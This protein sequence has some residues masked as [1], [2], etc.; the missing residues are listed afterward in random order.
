[1]RIAQVCP[2]SLS[3]PGGVQ[4]Q[5][6]GLARALRSRGH[7]VRVI[8][9]VDH[10][11]HEAGV[12]SV[13]SSVSLPA[14]GSRAP[15]APWPWSAATSL[16]ALAGGG[17]DLVHVHEPLVPGP[18]L[19]ALLA[20]EAP[21]VG[22]FHRSGRSL[23]YTAL[24]PVASLAAR[25]LAVRCAVSE[26]A[27]AT[28]AEALPGSYE[29]LF[30]GVDVDRFSA[31]RPWPREGP[32]VV[33]VG[34]HEARKGLAVLLKAWE[35]MPAGTRCWVVGEG[36]ETG[37]LKGAFAGRRGLE[38]VGAV[39]DAE[40]ASRLAGADVACL[41]SLR[42]E[43]FGLVLLEAMAAGTPV[44]ASDLPGYRGAAGHQ[45]AALLVAPGDP[46]A[47]GAAL[48]QVL[49]DPALSRAL[50]EAGT[51]RAKELSVERLAE[52]YETLYLDVV[53]AS[54]RP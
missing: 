19:A 47:L 7:L 18:S 22:T 42:G 15:V 1:M 39:E 30:N 29:V 12:V 8:A 6:V 14:N 52:R 28:A 31:A 2:Y 54:R 46:G 17:F 20:S 53:A 3:Y 27:A 21:V 5:V 45:G 25:R 23:A 13:G 11:V 50:V 34:R 16:R 51:R 9:P 33:F 10:P 37:R 26:E 40:R 48:R 24:A 36:P 41:P 44:V 43:S 4:S 32:T 35:A 49:D 38:W